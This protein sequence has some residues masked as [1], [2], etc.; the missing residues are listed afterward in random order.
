MASGATTVK[1]PKYYDLL[2]VTPD[3]GDTDIKKGL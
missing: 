1:D 3:A 2:G